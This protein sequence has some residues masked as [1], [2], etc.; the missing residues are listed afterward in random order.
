[1]RSLNQSPRP[2]N[3][4]SHTSDFLP[5]GRTPPSVL[6]SSESAAARALMGGWCR[7]CGVKE[8]A[9][10]TCRSCW[11]K[12][13]TCWSWVSKHFYNT[14]LSYASISHSFTAPS[15]SD[16]LT[17]SRVWGTEL[18]LLLLETGFYGFYLGQMG[19]HVCGQ[20][21]LDDQRAQLPVYKNGWLNCW[22]W[23]KR[24]ALCG[25]NEV[26]PFID[27]L[28]HSFIPMATLV[29]IKVIFSMLLVFMFGDI[30]T[31]EEFSWWIIQ[32]CPHPRNTCIKL[33]S[34]STISGFLFT[35]CTGG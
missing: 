21:H 2:S 29:A 33:L 12:H 3:T 9:L 27:A 14:D 28:V 22:R 25:M 11:R 30:C 20:H 4:N 6:W 8:T 24:N 17:H 15:F 23:I 18:P 31:A 32:Y 35:N 13:E 19:G 1:M 26:G 34:P 5:A 7:P 16:L 10:W